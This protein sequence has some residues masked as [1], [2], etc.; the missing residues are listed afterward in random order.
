MKR[1]VN[2]LELLVKIVLYPIAALF[3]LVIAYEIWMDWIWP[4]FAFI[5]ALLGLLGIVALIVIGSVLLVVVV[6][7]VVT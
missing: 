7:S 2:G 4:I 5:G 3:C 1:I 6:A